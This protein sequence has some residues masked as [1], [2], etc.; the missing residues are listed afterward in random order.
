MSK[1]RGLVFLIIL[2]ILLTGCVQQEKEEPASDSADNLS[3]PS[4]ESNNLDIAEN[5]GEKDDAGDPTSYFPE[6]EE[7]IDDKNEENLEIY[8][9]HWGRVFAKAFEPVD[10]PKPRDPQSLPAGYYKSPIIDAHIHIHSLPDGQPGFPDEYYTGTNLGIKYSLNQWLCMMDVEGTSKALAFFPVWDPIRNESLNLVKL[11]MEKYPHRFIPFIMPPD[12]DGSV[13]GSPTV[14]AS[15]LQE[16]L[17]VHPGLFKGYGE[18]GLYVRGEQGDP[19]SAPALPPDS[20]RLKEIYPH[21]REHNLVVYFHLGEG[22]KEALER[23]AAA[24][25]DITFIF[26]GDQLKDC[27]EC[28]K[29]HSMIADILEN[30]PNVYYGVDELYGGD[31]LLKPGASKEDFITHFEDY[32][33][34]LKKDLATF[35]EFIE[36]HPDQ[37]MWGSDRGVSTPWDVDP[38]VALVLNNYTRYFIGHL[39]PQV[40]EKLA[41]KNAQKLFE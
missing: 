1:K 17:S 7:A 23:V 29:T 2:V 14:D 10:C 9:Q 6:D 35:K 3:M 31:W 12:N 33:A 5:T 41:Y 37:V 11:V 18:I 36:T 27:A 24:N 21:I 30:H 19:K 25:P 20:T 40:Q 16:M 8:N 32:D 34:L 15:T 38:D 13:N 22:Q 4:E 26:H 39:D 28:D